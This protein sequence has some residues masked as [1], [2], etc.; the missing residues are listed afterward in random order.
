MIHLY[1]WATP[2]GRKISIMLEEVGLRY[3]VHS[4][5]IG[6]DEQFDPNFLAISPNNKI[7]A[8]VDSDGARRAAVVVRERRDPDLPR[9]KDRR[10]SRRRGRRDTGRWN[11]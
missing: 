6:R 11:G 4:V 1:T 10:F 5:N 7:P 2:N 8:I 9:G 3:T